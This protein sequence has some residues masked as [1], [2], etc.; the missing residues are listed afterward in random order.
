MNDFNP[1]SPYRSV[2]VKFP[3]LAIFKRTGYIEYAVD[4]VDQV[5]SRQG[6]FRIGDLEIGDQGEILIPDLD[7]VRY[8]PGASNL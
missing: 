7:K 3:Y 4:P 6:S 5:T 8:L 2:K 1:I